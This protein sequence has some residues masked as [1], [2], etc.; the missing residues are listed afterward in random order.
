MLWSTILKGL[1]NQPFI[2]LGRH[3]AP[4]YHDL[5][6]ALASAAG[7]TLQV[8]AEAR[9]FHDTLSL[10]SAGLGVSLLPAS[11]REHPWRGVTHWGSRSPS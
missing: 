10:V 4:V 6:L 9:N 8:Q 3:H 1:S 5:V 2:L 11:A 7:V